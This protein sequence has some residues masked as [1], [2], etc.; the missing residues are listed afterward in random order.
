[1][2]RVTIEFEVPPPQAAWWRRW[3]GAI[4][5]RLYP[6][7]PRRGGKPPVAVAMFQADSDNPEIPG[8]IVDP[9]GRVIGTVTVTEDLT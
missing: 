6:T 5:Y 7:I 3:A 9:V 1:M 8:R 4:Y 2:A